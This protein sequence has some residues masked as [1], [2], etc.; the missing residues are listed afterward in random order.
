MEWELAGAASRVIRRRSPNEA[1]LAFLI[2]AATNTVE[3][4]L[5][6]PNP[7]I[8]PAITNESAAGK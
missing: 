1:R 5:P 2:L 6:T 3:A 8:D 4:Q 7:N